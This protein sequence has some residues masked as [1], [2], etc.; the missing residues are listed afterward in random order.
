[1]N[2]TSVPTRARYVVVMFAITL[3]IIM[4][5]D[6]VC[7]SQAALSMR[8]DLGLTAVQMGWAFSIFGWAYALFEIPGGWLGDRIG[9]RRVLMRIVIWWSFFTAATGWVWNLPSLLATRALFGIGEA[10]CFPNLTRALATWLPKAE[11]ER[12]QATLWFSTRWAGALTPLLVAWVLQY[13]S[14]RR[15]F[16]I[17]GAIG[18]IWAIAFYRWYRDDP[19]THPSVNAAE[20]ALLPPASE[21]GTAHGT[22]W[23]L[24]L[25]TPAV[26]L[27]CVQYACLAYGWWFY[28]TWLPT[29]LRDVRGM[30]LMRGAFFA[31]L[32]L[33]LGGV[34]C[35]VSAGISPWLR[36]MTGSVILSRRILAITGFAG[37]SISIIVFTRTQDP[38][39][40]V[41][42]LGLAG[43]FNDFVMPPA[44]AGTMDVGGRHAGTVSG[45]MNMFGGIAGACSALV[46]GYILA[47]TNQD[48]TL[49]FYISSAIYMFGGLCWLFLDA[50][51]PFEKTRAG[52]A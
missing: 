13:V 15:A 52:S 49:T 33:F 28:V 6:R 9:P 23:G 8:S 18:V 44:W 27:L 30:S 16:E 45:A 36:R 7:I 22:P 34:G 32:P 19:H 10:G 42:L 46:V 41:F 39:V 21:T 25:R 17:F 31:G 3:A 20:K 14:W 35:F 12:A 47:W 48:W 43:F 11:R 38:L 24:M 51:T 29:Y 40:A 1:M 2:D 5:I 37:A 26:W 50:S 4:Y